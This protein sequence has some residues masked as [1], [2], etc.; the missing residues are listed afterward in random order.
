M[1]MAVAADPT[2]RDARAGDVRAF[3]ALLSPLIRPA[4]RLA[5]VALRNEAEAEDAVQEAAL[6]GWQKLGSFRGGSEQFRAWFLSIVVNECRM[7]R[8]R[9]WWS[10][11]RVADVAGRPS[12]LTEDAA[13]DRLDLRSLLE[14]LPDRDRVLLF[15]YFYLDLPI[16]EVARIGGLSSGAAKTRI[17]RALKRLGRDER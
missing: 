8:R 11:L 14:M 15:L 9:P 16:G 17:H 4:F 7:A 5:M 13:I 6:K 12:S 1:I 3:E 2:L 10:V